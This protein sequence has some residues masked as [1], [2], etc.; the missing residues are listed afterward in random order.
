MPD[1]LFSA[2]EPRADVLQGVIRESDYAADLSQVLKGEAPDEY[3]RADLFFAN[4]YPTKGLKNVLRLVALR[5]LGRPEQISAIFRLDTQFGGGKTHAL[6]ALSHVMG[7]MKDVAEA[8]EFLAAELRPIEQPA[9]AF[10]LDESIE[11]GL[12][13]PILPEPAH[14]FE[15]LNRLLDHPKLL[16]PGVELQRVRANEV[17]WSDPGRGPV[18]ITTDPAF[19]EEH[20]ESLELWSPGSPAFPIRPAETGN[21]IESS[22]GELI[23]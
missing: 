20:A 7:G 13:A 17:F 23:R 2:C 9:D 11:A 4:T 1:N 21:P 22:L 10:D 12:E 15:D 16:P 5:V 14:D 8:D 3:K 19:F 18:G 6:I